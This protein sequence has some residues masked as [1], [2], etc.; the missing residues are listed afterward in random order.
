MFMLSGLTGCCSLQVE[1]LKKATPPGSHGPHAGHS[2]PAAL[3]DG[4]HGH[5]REPAL[6]RRAA[7]LGV[8]AHHAQGRRVLFLPVL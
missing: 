7:G 2:A 4:V 8:P 1:A 3:V 5:H 6:L